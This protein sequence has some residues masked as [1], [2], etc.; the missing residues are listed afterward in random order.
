MRISRLPFPRMRIDLSAVLGNVI[1]N[2]QEATPKDGRVDVRLSAAPMGVIVEVDDTGCGM[3]EAFVRDRLFQPF[4]STKGLS[5]MGI[6]A[7]ECR[8]F[9]TMLG[10]R[11]E[12]D[13]RPGVGT[14]FSIFI[15]AELVDEGRVRG[16]SIGRVLLQDQITKL[17]IVEDDEGL[18]RQLRWSFD[19]CDVAVASDRESALLELARFGPAVVTLDLGLPPDPGGTSEGFKAL[20]D[21]LSQAPDTKVIVVTGHNDRDNA[22]RAI[23]RGAYDFY[24]KPVDPDLLALAVMRAARL[25]RLEQEHRHARVSWAAIAVRR[26]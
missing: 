10:G 16:E 9:V 13:S 18:Q 23:G 14:R 8:E 4:D 19:G 1:Q 26:V 25:A 21:I 6:G 3:D 2:A 24:E 11:I 17:L 5:G 22:V 7:Y 15:P 12:V 20:D